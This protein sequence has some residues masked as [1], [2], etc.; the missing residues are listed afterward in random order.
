MCHKFR[1]QFHWI[2]SSFLLLRLDYLVQCVTLTLIKWKFLY[3]KQC[4]PLPLNLLI[5]KGTNSRIK[6]LNWRPTSHSLNLPK[7][8]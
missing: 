7:G 2:R 3:L 5:S 1:Q 6:L 4:N 8:E